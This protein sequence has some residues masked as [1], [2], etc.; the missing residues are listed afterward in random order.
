M[1][2]AR[3][4]SAS[5][6]KPDICVLMI[7]ALTKTD[8]LHTAMPRAARR[9]WPHSP[10]RAGGES[11]VTPYRQRCHR[12]LCGETSAGTP[13]HGGRIFDGLEDSQGESASRRR[14][15]DFLA[16]WVCS[17]DRF[18]RCEGIAWL[19][20]AETVTSAAVLEL[21]TMTFSN[22]IVFSIWLVF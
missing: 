20:Y 14:K 11:A 2:V 3:K 7:D 8:R 1:T 21:W 4:I 19:F 17:A 16:S 10:Q 6:P 22:D 13:V 12:L 18:D 9:Q 15:R 5:L